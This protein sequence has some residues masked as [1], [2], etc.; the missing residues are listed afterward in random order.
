MNRRTSMALTI[1]LL[2]V[3]IA[4]PLAATSVVPNGAVQEGADT[5]NGSIAPG[6]QLSAAVGVQDADLEGDVSERAFG[7]ELANAESD[8][9]KAA[10]I[11]ERHGED[12]ERLDELEGRLEVLNESREAGEISEGRYRAEVA[13]VVAEMGSVERRAAIGAN[14]AGELPTD[15]LSA[16]GVDVD[17]IRTLQE[18][19]GE[20]GGPDVAA[21]ARSIAGAGVGQP[22]DVPSPGGD[23]ETARDS[24]NET[25]GDR[26]NESDDEGSSN[27]G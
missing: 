2:V 12:E 11:A 16:Q 20:R 21:T 25:A 26:G 10:I 27:G 22:T 23:D 3:A 15:V 5:E 9:A 19:A 24:G 6:E 1:A 4:V 17:E 8:E 18:R 7:L 13:K 14:A